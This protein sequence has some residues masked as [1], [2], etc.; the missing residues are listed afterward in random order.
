MDFSSSFRQAVT[1]RRMVNM[2]VDPRLLLP[3]IYQYKQELFP[4]E[5]TLS[6]YLFLAGGGNVEASLP[7]SFSFQPLDCFLLIYITMGGGRLS[8]QNNSISVTE[9]TLLL[10]DCCHPFTLQSVLLPWNFEIFFICGDGTKLFSP[11]FKK[12]PAA[13][14]Q[15]ADYPPVISQLN[16][17]SAIPE[18][19]DA[20]ALLQ[21]H[22]SL[23]H[24]FCLFAQPKNDA[25]KTSASGAGPLPV[26]LAKMKRHMDAHYTESFSLSFYEELL[27]L[28]KY[29]LCREFSNTFGI[30]PLK[31]INQKRLETAKELLLTTELNVQE[32][33]S[34]AGYENVN[35]FINLFKKDTGYTPKGFRQKAQQVPPVLRSPFQ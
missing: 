28:N 25:G 33:S 8:F 3:R 15:E 29:R 12:Q 17:L 30:S 5:V 23:T 34:S 24:L 20:S 4:P 11:F 10:F 18:T 26:Y 32:I 19:V 13:L 35:H 9:N 27:K 2:D 1:S 22:Q 21:M 6:N 7:F 31:Y 16:H 14:L